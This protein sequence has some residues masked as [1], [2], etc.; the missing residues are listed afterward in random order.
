M[1]KAKRLDVRMPK[2]KAGSRIRGQCTLYVPR[3]AAHLYPLEIPELR[4]FDLQV[5]RDWVLVCPRPLLC[6]LTKLRRPIT[7]EVDL[8]SARR[9]A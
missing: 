7:L 2:R 3:H 4:K 6:L 8:G 5:A 1:D 9:Q